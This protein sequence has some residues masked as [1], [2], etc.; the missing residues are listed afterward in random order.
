M[1]KLS[2]KEWQSKLEK[3]K[4]YTI[5]YKYVKFVEKTKVTRKIRRA[6][7]DLANAMKEGKP[8]DDLKVNLESLLDDEHYINKFPFDQKYI[9]LF[10]QSP[11]SPDALATQQKIRESLRSSRVKANETVKGPSSKRKLKDDF[12][13]DA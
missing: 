13:T 6:R 7:Q 1:G 12:F 9:S 2:G 4:K 5:Q 3:G 10:P 8:C 11:L